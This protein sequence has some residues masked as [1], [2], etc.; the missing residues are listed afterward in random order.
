[1][2]EYKFNI[3][4]EVVMA[5]GFCGKI[6]SICECDRCKE[7]GFLEPIVEWDDD[8]VDWITEWDLYD[9]FHNYYMIGNYTFGN[10]HL[11]DVKQQISETKNKLYQ[12]E[13]QRDLLLYI[14]ERRENNLE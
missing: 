1:M 3:G 14:L 6:I 2:N 5:D 10:I 8:N 9:G 13:E 7:R 12:L 4:D 11:E